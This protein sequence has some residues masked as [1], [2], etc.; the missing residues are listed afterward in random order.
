VKV[1]DWWKRETLARDVGLTDEQSNLEQCP[2]TLEGQ[3]G[4]WGGG[5]RICS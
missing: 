4:A 3:S 1:P 5:E 2:E